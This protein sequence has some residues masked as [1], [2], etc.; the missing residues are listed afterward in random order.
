MPAVVLT[1]EIQ[2]LTSVSNKLLTHNESFTDF[3][4]YTKQ[5]YHEILARSYP[6]HPFI[7][8]LDLLLE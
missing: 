2:E 5:P 4:S 8:P 6:P 1:A 3:N 7:I